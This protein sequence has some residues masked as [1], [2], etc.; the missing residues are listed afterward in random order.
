MTAADLIGELFLTIE[1]I[2]GELDKDALKRVSKPE[3][4][5]NKARRVLNGALYF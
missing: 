1:W 2:V 5:P 3:A 4:K